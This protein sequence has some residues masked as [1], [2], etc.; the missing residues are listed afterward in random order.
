MSMNGAR[1]SEWEEAPTLPPSR[2][3]HMKG[4]A[5]MAYKCTDCDLLITDRL[6]SLRTS[7]QCPSM[8]CGGQMI[9]S[10][11][12]K[13]RNRQAEFAD[14]SEIT[15]CYSCCR[16]FDSERAQI[17]GELVHDHFGDPWWVCRE[18]TERKDEL[19]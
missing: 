9:D 18:C 2:P 16:A 19:Q 10:K 14:E 17:E 3:H 11:P 13:M 15:I 6:Q 8:R 12:G 5:I 7:W 1:D 4:G